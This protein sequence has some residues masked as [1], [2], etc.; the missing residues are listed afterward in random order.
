[1]RAILTKWLRVVLTV[2]REVAF[3]YDAKKGSKRAL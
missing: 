3:W 2:L 1:M